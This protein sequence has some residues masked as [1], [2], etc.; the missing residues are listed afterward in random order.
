L[1]TLFSHK[2]LLEVSFN[3]PPVDILSAVANV[4]VLDL[5]LSVQLVRNT[6]NLQ[7]RIARN[8]CPL[9]KNWQL[10]FL[11]QMQSCESICPISLQLVRKTNNLQ[12]GI[13]TKTLG[14]SR[15]L[16]FLLQLQICV[17]IVPKILP[18]PLAEAKNGDEQFWQ[19]KL[20][21]ASGKLCMRSKCSHQVPI[22]F[23]HLF[24]MFVTITKVR[25]G[26]NFERT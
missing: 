17:T 18:L 2:F 21:V 3:T 26:Q 20:H 10:I 7:G 15:K 11:L 14:P 1:Q 8:L 23:S 5:S 4:Y 6:N 13:I 25:E 24:L 19:E 12:F 9:R 16:F 22:T